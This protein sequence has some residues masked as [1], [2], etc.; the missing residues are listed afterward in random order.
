MQ[1][2][3]PA[4][5]LFGV[6]IRVTPA[7]FVALGVTAALFALRI[8]PDVLTE[9]SD[10]TRWA[11]GIATALLFFFCILLHELG[12]AAV[13]RLFHVP[14]RGITLFLLGGVAQIANE[15][16]DPVTELSIAGAGP[17]V[18]LALT[19][20]CFV[21]AQLTPGGRVHAGF[22]PAHTLHV[23]LTAL[24]L[25]NL[26]VG[27][28]NLIPGFPM[29]GGRLLRALIWLLTGS[30]LWATRIAGWGGR[31]I[32]SGMI[33]LGL[34][35]V[36]SVPG[37]PLN[38]DV[39]AGVQLMLVGGYLLNAAHAADVS[40]RALATL[41]RYTASTLVRR[42]VPLV[43]AGALLLDF[44]PALMT[45]GDC[46]TAFVIDGAAGEDRRVV[47]LLGREAALL[48]PVAQRARTTARQIMLPAATIRPAGPDDDGAALLQRLELEGLAA[49]PVV[50]AGELLG[51]VNWRALTRVLERR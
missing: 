3:Y 30:Y 5:R 41:R 33:V 50:A 40:E 43:D 28:F 20:V 29:D 8:Y 25:L 4:G 27:V 1:G 18:S 39:L 16:R 38:G 24:W 17:A 6:P 45:A 48:L 44:L 49:L 26:S 10:S 9:S 15:V 36:L 19:G 12:H 21:L 46:D 7:W 37:A 2:S 34:A 23:L 35:A 13:A 51:V 31:F 14:V 11:L 22:D 47:G 32:A 42:D